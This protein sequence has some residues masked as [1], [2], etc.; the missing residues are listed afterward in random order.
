VSGLF[1]PHHHVRARPDLPQRVGP[2]VT[3]VVVGGGIAGVSAALVLAERGVRVELLEAAPHLGGRLGTWDTRLS[4]GSEVVVEH[5]YHGFFRQ[6]YTLRDVLRRIDP[7]LGFLRDVGGYPIASR[8][9][10]G[11]ESEDFT[12]LPRTPLLNLVALVLRSPSFKLR[13]LRHVNADE[14]LAMLHY[15]PARTYAEHDHRSAAD[16]LDSLGFSDRG[17]AMLFEVFAH[18]FFNVEQRYS[19]A[20]FLAMCHFYFT[21]N[22]E[23]LGM[24]APTEDYRTCLWEPFTRLLEKHGATVST[25]TRAVALRPD[26]ARGWVVDVER[27]P[28]RRAR[29]L[30]VATD[31]PAT[32]DLVAASPEL[33]AAAPGLARRI[34]ALP[35]GEPYVVAR[36]F[37]E[38][39]VDPSRAVFTGV[40][41]ERV[42]DSV[43]LFHRLE[44]GSAR[45]AAG[46]DTGAGPGRRSVVE[47]HSYA[48]PS[49]ATLDELV[50]AMREELAALWPEAADLRVLDVDAHRYTNAPGF[51]PGFHLVRPGV[52]TDARG[53]RLAGD[54]VGCDVPSALMERAAVT[55][56]TAANDVLREEGVGPEPMRSIR[57]RGILAGRR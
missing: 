24:D 2:D 10:V 32:R 16:L 33:V 53:L 21:G 5:G 40:T 7:E 20:E 23:G 3:A 41:R 13:E 37:C 15:D 26:G 55:A 22:P 52:L 9:S 28:A 36:L 1:R 49:G 51:D 31:V 19:A 48:C 4:D 29:H 54:W 45:W 57:P 14:A 38:G 12:A 46:H 17:R 34:A 6:Y 47:L 43:T 30:V 11:W 42:L 8:P 50:A 27:E 44:G 18:S 39:D 35:G 25:G 56:V